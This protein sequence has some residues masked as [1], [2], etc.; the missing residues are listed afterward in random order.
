MRAH[1]FNRCDVLFT[2]NTL[3]YTLTKDEHY[4][5]MIG[6]VN[7]KFAVFPAKLDVR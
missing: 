4:R 7:P 6:E 5:K 2:E 1:A 3:I